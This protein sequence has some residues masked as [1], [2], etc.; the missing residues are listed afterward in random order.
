MSDRARLAGAAIKFAHISGCRSHD[1]IRAME[2]LNPA[3]IRSAQLIDVDFGDGTGVKARRADMAMLVFEGI[4]P[5]PLMNAAQQLVNNHGLP[6]AERLDDEE[7]DRDKMIEV[8]R[9]HAVAVVVEPVIVAVDDGDATHLP[10]TLLTLP[11]LLAIWNQTAATPRLEPAAAA[12]FRV[13]PSGP[14]APVLPVRQDLRPAAKPVDYASVE[15][16]YG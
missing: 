10:V 15:Y 7:I 14:T 12:R 5:T 2:L 3:A 11:Q 13:R 9:R 16:R 6:V 8:L 4:V 1:R